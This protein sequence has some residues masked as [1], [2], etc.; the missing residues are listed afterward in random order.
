MEFCLRWRVRIEKR[1][2]EPK[3]SGDDL[4]ESFKTKQ[5]TTE[6]VGFQPYSPF[7][8]YKLFGFFTISKCNVKI[9]PNHQAFS[10]L[11]AK[12]IT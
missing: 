11:Y 6:A 7:R 12:W 8:F 9:N 10:H 5:R 4:R 2:H 1:G 3:A